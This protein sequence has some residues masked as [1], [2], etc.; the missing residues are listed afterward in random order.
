M[1]QGQCAPALALCSE[2]WSFPS[3]APETGSWWVRRLLREESCLPSAPSQFLPTCSFPLAARI[4]VQQRYWKAPLPPLYFQEEKQLHPRSG[5][6]GLGGEGWGWGEGDVA[7]STLCRVVIGGPSWHPLPQLPLP[8]EEEFPPTFPH[9]PPG[10][11]HLEK[12]DGCRQTSRKVEQSWIGHAGDLG[13]PH[14][15]DPG[16]P[17]PLGTPCMD[18]V[19]LLLVAN[20]LEWVQ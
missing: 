8:K 10:H 7:H 16:V 9:Q 1:G 15:Q 2:R 14:R 20:P 5:L 3:Q 18:L 11:P 12:G 13:H 17:F 19:I 6:R 4:A